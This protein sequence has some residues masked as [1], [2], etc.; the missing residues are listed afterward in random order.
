MAG[1]NAA[2]ILSSVPMHECNM[3]AAGF[4]DLAWLERGFQLS[5]SLM[6]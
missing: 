3:F 4:Q 1:E 5:C 2:K 6:N